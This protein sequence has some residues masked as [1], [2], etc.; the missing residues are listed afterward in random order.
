MRLETDE[1]KTIKV[2][3]YI[4]KGGQGAVYQVENDAAQV[5]KVYE[6]PTK[7]LEDKIKE[8]TRIAE[9]DHPPSSCA[10]WPIAPVYETL[11]RWWWKKTKFIGYTMPYIADAHPIFCFYTPKERK[12]R[13]WNFTWAD[14]HRLAFNVSTMFS[15]F[16]NHSYVI[17]D[18]NC[19][20]I[21]VNAALET[22]MIDI[23]S[24][25]IS[26]RYTTDVG[27]E[28]YTPPEL[29][30]KSLKHVVR[31]T[32][33]D[34]F[35]LGY[36]IFQLLMNGCSPFAGVPKIDLPWPYVDKKCKEFGIFPFYDNPYVAP[37]PGMPNIGV[38]HPELTAGFINCFVKGRRNPTNRPT[39]DAWREKL[40]RARWS[41]IKCEWD[42]AHLY[43]SHLSYCPW[44]K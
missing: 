40:K 26:S 19:K 32:N 37:P 15:E 39:A 23:D 42:S 28:E 5:V 33:H 3:R 4:G 44:C 24:I 30:G 34:L 31:N 17:G 21:L 35:G 10:A 22:V 1:G 9:G 27:F 14:M 6:A 41:L 25:Q 36:L 2:G 43:S 11:G 7:K 29:A 38:F 16:H 8:M 18:V 13:K 12:E 20:N